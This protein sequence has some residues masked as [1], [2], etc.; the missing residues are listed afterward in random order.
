VKPPESVPPE[1]EQEAEAKRPDGVDVIRQ[2]GPP[3]KFE[4]EAVT[5]VPGRP[6]GGVNASVGAKGALNWAC[7][8]SPLVPV[9]KT[10]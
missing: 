3:R 7:P 9:T 2:K 1:S 8:A 5:G 10:V 6:E 4:P